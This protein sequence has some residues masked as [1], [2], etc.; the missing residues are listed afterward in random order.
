VTPADA[1]P[2]ARRR[3]RRRALVRAAALGYVALL[4]VAIGVLVA[5]T[6]FLRRAGTRLGLVPPEERTV[7][8][9]VTVVEQARQDRTAADGALVLLGDSIATQ[10]DGSRIAG[11]AVNYGIG[12]DTT[13]TL[14]WRLPLL[15]SVESARVVVANVGVNDL[16][17]RP[18]PAIAADYRAL[19]A[20]FPPSARLV[21]ISPLPVDERFVSARGRP[22]LGNDALRSLNAA[23]RPLCEARPGCRF[24]DAWPVFWDGAAGGMRRSLHRGDGLHLSPEGSRA[25]EALIRSAIGELPDISRR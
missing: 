6:D 9:A 1:A 16:R 11:D 4:H 3:R 22:D 19:L 8:L 25:L 15:R 13:R 18:V 5:K 10:L 24:L 12:G 14:L 17:F 7:E 21:M 23:V 20:A 2:P